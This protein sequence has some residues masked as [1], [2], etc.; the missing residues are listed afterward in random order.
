[1]R[2]L[3]G[4]VRTV[5]VGL[6]ERTVRVVLFEITVWVGLFER[7][8]WVVLTFEINPFSSSVSDN[9]LGWSI[10]EYRLGCPNL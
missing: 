3:F 9:C 4:L 8:V 5:K 6:F 2:E 1:L 7:T 10:S